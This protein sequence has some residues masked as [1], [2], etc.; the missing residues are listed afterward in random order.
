M[1]LA[2]K[3]LLLQQEQEQE[4]IQETTAAA[5]AAAQSTNN[6]SE[7]G[8]TGRDTSSNSASQKPLLACV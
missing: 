6:V 3:E 2:A 8:A 7:I 4:Q 1:S 5:A